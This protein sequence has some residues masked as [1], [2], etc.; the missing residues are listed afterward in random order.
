MSLYTAEM[1]TAVRKIP[2]PYP[3]KALMDII[4]FPTGQIGLR[5][6][7]NNIMSLGVD[8]RVTFMDYLNTIR[9][10]IESFG[11]NCILD[12]VSGDPPGRI[13]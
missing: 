6:Y 5:I 7:E 4:E 13:R 9:S 1:R 12:G 11:V 8:Q 2:N 10:I 3:R